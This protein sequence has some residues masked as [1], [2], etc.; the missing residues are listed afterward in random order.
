M[1]ALADRLEDLVVR[2]ADVHARH[3]EARRHDLIDGRVGEREHPEQHVALRDAEGG[4]Q[5]ARRFDQGVQAAIR[6]RQQPEQRAERRERAARERQRGVGQL[7]RQ[8]GDAARQGVPRDEQQQRAD[9]E[10]DQRGGPR[11]RPPGDGVRRGHGAEHEERQPADVQGAVQRHAAFGG[12]G[13]RI[14]ERMQ[15]FA[16]RRL[17]GECQECGPDCGRQGHDQPGDSQCGF[18]EHQRLRRRRRTYRSWRRHIRE[19]VRPGPS[20]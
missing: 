20:G 10:R 18:G 2:R 7:G 8:A 11:S 13:W 19:R 3:V 4:L 15:R 6:P 16:D 9:A 1:L 5:R 17:L 12:H 14:A